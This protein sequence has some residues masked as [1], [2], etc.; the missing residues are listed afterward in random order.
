MHQ[1]L[2]TTGHCYIADEGLASKVCFA[3]LYM[4]SMWKRAQIICHTHLIGFVNFESIH[5][6]K[7]SVSVQSLLNTDCMS[8]TQC[9]N[10]TTSKAY[11]IIEQNQHL[12]GAVLTKL[13]IIRV[14]STSGTVFLSILQDFLFSRYSGFDECSRAHAYDNTKTIYAHTV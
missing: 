13:N 12:S 7:S 4:L 6:A 11:R 8:I 5:A 10:N 2:T 9:R 3:V 1:H 14:G